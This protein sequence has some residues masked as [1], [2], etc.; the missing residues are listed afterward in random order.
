MPSPS[1]DRVRTPE[2]RSGLRP[3][4]ESLLACDLTH[5]LHDRCTRTIP[6]KHDIEIVEFRLLQTGI[7]LRYLFSWRLP[8]FD[9][10]VRGMVACWSYRQGLRHCGRKGHMHTKVDGV[11]RRHFAA[12]R[13]H[14]KSRHRVS[15]IAILAQL[16]IR[17]LQPDLLPIGYLRAISPYPNA[18]RVQS[19][20]HD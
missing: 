12:Q 1:S 4:I 7:E 8:T 9:L 10:L 20:L 2:E 11:D 13:L 19:A 16:E 15:D 5:L 18:L 17:E 6:R 3:S 14:D